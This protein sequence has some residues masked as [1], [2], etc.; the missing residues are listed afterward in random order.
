[1]GGQVDSSPRPS[2]VPNRDGSAVGDQPLS[3]DSRISCLRL[4]TKE[5]H[6]LDVLGVETVREFLELDL[7]VSSQ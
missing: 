2:E 1:M 5:Q 7:R 3:P 4:S 6:A